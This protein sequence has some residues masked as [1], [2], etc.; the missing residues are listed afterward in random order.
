MAGGINVPI[1]RASTIRFPRFHD[2]EQARKDPV[3][4]ISYGIYG[5]STVKA[6]EHAMAE[7]EGGASARAVSSGL[8]A[9]SAAICAL[10]RSG[11]HILVVDAAYGPVRRLC[12]HLA[13]AMQIKVTYYTPDTG[14]N[15]ADLF[16]PETR[17]VYAESPGSQ[18]FEIQ[19][20]P[21]I[22]A[23]A[24]ARDLP[25][26]VDNTWATPM[27][28]DPLMLGADI[29]VHAAT[30]YIC[31][32]SDVILG[33]VICNTAHADAV[34]R[35]INTMGMHVSPDDCYVALRGLR[36][37]MARLRRHEENAF[38]VAQWLRQQ[39]QVAAVLHPGL[40]TTPGHEIWKRDFR[41][42]TGL[43]SILLDRRYPRPAVEALVDGLKLFSIGV[44]WGGYES[45]ALPVFPHPVRS[46]TAWND[47]G[48]LVRLHIGLE[49]PTDLLNDLEAG[50]MLLEGWDPP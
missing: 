48:T 24:K 25:V 40:P 42:A 26:I 50:L 32:Y 18:T 43:F 9:I 11:D 23:A 21:A 5:T 44:S 6:F 2:L 38:R 16:R 47:R 34:N 37:L 14:A 7:L 45:L 36:S 39:P 27:F 4:N 22:C 20:I 41:G 33:V 30:K 29:V 13:E 35:Y 49:N 15:I 1:Q 31:G 10:V 8:A 17:L 12:D 46:T 19:D 28:C 3:A